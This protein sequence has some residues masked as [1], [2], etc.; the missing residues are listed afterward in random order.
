MDDKKS[1]QLRPEVLQLALLHLQDRV[2]E[3]TVLVIVRHLRAL[4]AEEGVVVLDVLDIGGVLASLVVVQNFQVDA[5]DS[6]YSAME[7]VDQIESMLLDFIDGTFLM[8]SVALKRII[9]DLLGG[10][11]VAFEGSVHLIVGIREVEGSLQLCQGER[12][13][14]QK[15]REVVEELPQIKKILKL[16]CLDEDLFELWRVF[17]N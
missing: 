17:Q 2:Y 12:G 7:L 9:R 11:D 14:I 5:E 1:Y 4:V 3:H 13:Q 8:P 16:F 6:D 15:V 10:I